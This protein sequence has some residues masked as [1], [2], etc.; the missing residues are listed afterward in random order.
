MHI[1]VILSTACVCVCTRAC[2]SFSFQILFMEM[3]L[4]CDSLPKKSHKWNFNIGA[5]IYSWQS[6]RVKTEEE[7]NKIFLLCSS[8]FSLIVEILSCRVVCACVSEEERRECSALGSLLHLRE[9]SAAAAA[10]AAVDGVDFF[11]LPSSPQLHCWEE[12]TTHSRVWRSLRFS[13]CQPTHSALLCL[14]VCPLGLL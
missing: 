12:S 6:S 9:N 3:L 1:F 14:S 2:A 13:P 8:T 4:P 5:Q 7:E 11:T 10:A